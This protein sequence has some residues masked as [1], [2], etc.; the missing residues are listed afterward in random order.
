MSALFGEARERLAARPAQNKTAGGVATPAPLQTVKAEPPTVADFL[1]TVLPDQGYYCLF[2]L[3]GKRHE[4]ADSVAGLAELVEK[5][6]DRQGIYFATASFKTTEGRTQANV[7]AL[8]AFRFDIDAGEKKHSKDPEGTYPDQRTALAALVGF[9]KATT[10]IPSYIVSSGEGLHVYYCLDEVATPEEW[11]PVAAGLGRLAASHGLLVDTSV[12]TDTA[13]VLRPLGT[14]HKNGSRVTLLRGDGRLFSID[15][16]RK[17]F[18]AEP[19][20][21][22]RKYDTSI[23]DEAIS[24]FEGPP[25]SALKIAQHC[26]AV[27]EVA[28]AKGDVQEPFWRAMLGVVKHT[29]EGDELAHEWSMGY[30]GYD[31]RETQRKLD[32]WATGPSTCA[33]FS[34]HAKACQSCPHR[35]NIKSPIVL[36]QTLDLS[37]PGAIATGDVAGAPPEWS[38][39][40]NA[41]HAVVRMG[42]NMVIAD[43]M[44]ASMNGQG[45]TFGLGW[46]TISAFRQMYKG[47][48]IA[49]ETGIPGETRRVPLPDAWLA[50]ASRRQFEGAVFAPGKKV[51]ASILNLY[52]GFAVAPADG[53]VS[54]WLRL[55]DALIPDPTVRQY[56]LCWLAWKVQN[57]G[58]VP[59]TI[60]I[61][62]GSKGT[63]KNSL[64][65]PVLILFGR[66][67]MLADDPELIAGRFTW[68]L[69]DKCFAVLDEAVFIGDPRQQDRI[70]SRTTAKVMLYEQKGMD[71]VQGVNCCAYV[72]LTNHIHVWQTTADERRA[73]IV[74]VGDALRGNLKFW[75]DYH[76][77][78]QHDGPAALLHYLQRLDVSDFNPRRIPK[79]EALRKQIEMTALR[80]PAVAWWH[81]CLSEGAIRWREGGIE[82]MV[83]LESNAA[84]QIDLHAVRESFEQSAG[85]RTRNGAG[86][87]QVAKRIHSWCGPEGLHKSR[88]R[89]G[90]GDQR[91]PRYTLPRLPE[92]RSY[93]AEATNVRIES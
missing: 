77:W 56:V 8:K 88:P 93:F 86:W 59:D 6:K 3:D 45:V 58:G 48:T 53:D 46:L 73:V 32:A 64:F 20:A 5:Y 92:L 13:R 82:R 12:T 72:M 44:T 31:E 23:N 71:P 9:I 62:T 61:L 75:D 69:M 66:H 83:P 16:L 43:H 17:A 25:S 54:L 28:Q 37:P 27:D 21:P 14:L 68:H 52:Q 39:T 50:H 47:R 60:L 49:A 85:G 87:A 33:E 18:P 10:L 15:S 51:P 74:E 11:V 24:G 81:Q 41:R 22:T 91:L 90:A 38:A 84:T 36:G 57:P 76:A 67:G 2:L 63:G 79:G 26:G 80:D 35:G 89:T 19:L 65:D 42:S 30:D 1:A 70:K 7:L 78:V 40:L 4:W 55:L 34:K 29:V